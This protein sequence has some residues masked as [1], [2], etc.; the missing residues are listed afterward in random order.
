[1][2]Y[3][4]NVLDDDFVRNDGTLPEISC[5]FTLDKTIFFE[6]FRSYKKASAF[7]AFLKT[8]EA[9]NWKVQEEVKWTDADD[10]SEVE[11]QYKGSIGDFFNSHTIETPHADDIKDAGDSE[12]ADEDDIANKTVPFSEVVFDTF[13]RKHAPNFVSFDDDDNLIP[14]EI[15]LEYLAPTNTK[16]VA[17]QQFV[18]GKQ[19]VLNLLEVA[20][21]KIED[22]ATANTGRIKQYMKSRNL[23]IN[24]QFQD[25]WTQ[26]IGD[27]G[28][29]AIEIELKNHDSTIITAA[30]KPYF[31]FWIIDQDHGLHPKQRSKGVRWFLS[32]YISLKADAKRTRESKSIFLIDEP[33]AN[34]HARA[35]EDVLRVF[36]EIASTSQIIYTT[37]SQHLVEFDKIHRVLAVQRREDA[38]EGSDTV[39]IPAYHLG[40]ASSNTLAP[41]L[42]QMGIDFSSQNVIKKDNNIILE[43]VSAMYYLRGFGM[44]TKSK[45]HNYL[46]ATGVSNVEQ[47]VRLFLGWGLNFGVLMDDDSA[48]RKVYNSLL[49]DLYSDD[50]QMAKRYI[51]KIKGCSGIEDIF[52]KNDF[53]KI[54][55]RDESLFSDERQNSDLVKGGSYSKPMLAINFLKAVKEGKILLSDF[56]PETRSKIES[57]LKETERISEAPEWLS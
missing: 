21:I 33:G 46:P 16:K 52:S 50:A 11:V 57:L 13:W 9:A 41:I 5:E 23:T 22:I 14:N 47:L 35:Q 55:L 17:G 36:E 53:R 42:E 24:A 31:E 29:I 44:M 1:M 15:D 10:L 4:T 39:I 26:K 25:F 38:K 43:E 18:Q 40:S 45:Q 54:I 2:A 19:A 37:H 28:K 6:D 7:V 48:G 49:R 3:Q 8:L 12:V 51:Y 56:E 34:L 32:F 27:G 20:G 30:G